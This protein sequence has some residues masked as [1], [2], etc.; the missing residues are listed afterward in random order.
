MS[1]KD[2]P[3]LAEM[4]LKNPD[5]QLAG[6]QETG[7]NGGKR[8]EE[9]RRFDLCAHCLIGLGARD[10][11]R[12]EAGLC[13]YGNDIDATTTPVEVFMALCLKERIRGSRIHV[14]T[15]SF[16]PHIQAALGWTMGGPKARRRKEQGFLGAEK[17]L[18]PE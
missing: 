10:S 16:P 15:P 18:T 9:K 6:K 14:D 17:F 2:A 1:W 11:L 5:V 4:L 7:S 12:L 8:N 3:I 13:L